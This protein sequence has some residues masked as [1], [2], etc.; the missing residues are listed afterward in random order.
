MVVRSETSWNVSRSAARNEDGAAA[1]FF[2][3]G[4]GGEKIIRLEAGRFHILKAAGGNKFR[5]HIK[6]LKQG[7]VEAELDAE[8][9]HQN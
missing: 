2:R 3:C 9:D 5:Q 6:L 7:I 8:R 4:S 1:L